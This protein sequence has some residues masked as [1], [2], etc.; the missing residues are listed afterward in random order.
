MAIV[1]NTY[2]RYDAQGLREQ[3]DNIISDLSPMDT[4]GV[5]GAGRGTATQTLFE[6]QTDTLAAAVTTNQ[7]IEGDDISS[8][9]ASV[10]TVRT[11]NYTQISR[12]TLIVSGTLD[13]VS[14]AGRQTELA[15]QIPRR[16]R[17]I[18]RDQESHMWSNAA[19]DAGGTATARVSAALGAWIK[20]NDDFGSGG[21]S[22]VWT[23]GVPGAGRTDG[24]QRAFTETILKAVVQLCWNNGA[25]PDQ[26]GVGPVN[27][28]R[29]SETFSGIATQTVN[30]G[31]TS[32]RPTIAVASIDFYVS[33]FGTL[34]IVPNRFQ[35]ERDAWLIDYDHVN[36]KVLRGFRV[37]KLA[38][39]GD[40]EKR[41]L[42]IEYGIEVTNELGFGLC[43]DLT[44]T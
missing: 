15:Y 34:R 43:A 4:P 3:L 25:T 37:E 24:T 2:T 30:I 21:A 1:A 5:T 20:T 13:A 31:D 39:T 38:K 8:F 14:K 32:H 40:A 6:T 22:P 12:K 35:Q 26:I 42:L 16:G 11:G 27:K 17:E 9:D 36:F 41:M 19:G 28:K 29:M 7:Q 18:K 10:A 33:D 44:T 23:S